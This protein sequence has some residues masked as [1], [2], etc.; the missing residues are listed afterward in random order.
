[1]IFN[2]VHPTRLSRFAGFGF[3]AIDPGSLTLPSI[4]DIMGGI[5]IFSDDVYKLTNAGR[6]RDGRTGSFYDLWGRL[7]AII[8][9]ASSVVDPKD[10]LAVPMVGAIKKYLSQMSAA[11]EA[12]KRALQTMGDDQSKQLRATNLNIVFDTMNDAVN[13]L[14]G[15][16]QGA[17]NAIAQRADDAAAAAAAQ[18]QAQAQ[19]QAAA[20]QAAAAAQQTQAL[21]AQTQVAQQTTQL[22][23][24]TVAKVAADQQLVQATTT[25]VLGIPVGDLFG[26]V[27]GLA[28]LGAAWWFFKGRKKKSA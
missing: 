4:P 16:I 7:Q 8:N 13:R 18:A 2:R 27:G 19:A 17:Q 22:D 14:P 12:S 6:H 5:D 3:Y 1:M 23:Q 26:G 24:A 21:Q 10:P 11:I 15:I 9:G 25:K 20:A 28:L